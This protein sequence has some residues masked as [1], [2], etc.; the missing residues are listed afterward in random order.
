MVVRYRREGHDVVARDGNGV[1]VG[2][3]PAPPGTGDGRMEKAPRHPVS[4]L[5]ADA[6]REPVPSRR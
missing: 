2:R 3:F 1:E 4:S 5:R 6:G